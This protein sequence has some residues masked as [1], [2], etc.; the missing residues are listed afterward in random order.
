M[1]TIKLLS[2]ISTVIIIL[3]S[4]SNPTSNSEKPKEPNVQEQIVECKCSDM[5]VQRLVNTIERDFRQ[6]QNALESEY[7]RLISTESIDKRDNCTWVVTFK[8]Y[9]PFGA[10]PDEYVKK[11]VAC[12]GKEVYTQ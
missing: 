3:T 9:W 7:A 1:K 11:R 10:H 12:D 6:S 8:I 4:C 2:S 5:D